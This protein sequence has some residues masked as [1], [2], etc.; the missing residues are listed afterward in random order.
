AVD[1]VLTGVIRRQGGA[2]VPVLLDQV[3]E[4]PAAVPHVDLRVVEVVDPEARAAGVEGDSL[5]RVRQELHQ[6]DRARLGACVRLELRLLVDDRREQRRVE[7]VIVRMA[8]HDLLVAKWV[9]EPVPPAGPRG[10]ENGERSEQP[11]GEQHEHEDAL[12]AVSRAMTS[13][14]NASS[15]SKVPSFTYE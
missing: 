2:F 11:A 6:A 13:A 4:V 7:V 1:V 5:G 8:S 12:H 14:T 15:S 10:L 9:P 3:L